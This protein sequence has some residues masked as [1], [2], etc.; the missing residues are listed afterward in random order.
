ME[1]EKE[2]F[3]SFKNKSKIEKEQYID[4]HEQQYDELNKELKKLKLKCDKLDG[5][6][7]K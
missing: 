5:I 1:N 6:K 2:K 3:V 7:K 4:K